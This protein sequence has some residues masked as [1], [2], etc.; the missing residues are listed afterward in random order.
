MPLLLGLCGRP[1]AAGWQVTQSAAILLAGKDLN[2]PSSKPAHDNQPQ[3]TEVSGT[4]FAQT[5]E[6]SKQL[7]E[8]AD[9]LPLSPNPVL[10]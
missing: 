8:K 9:S 3:A 10:T 6:I 1:G 5:S 4:S 7:L 2:I